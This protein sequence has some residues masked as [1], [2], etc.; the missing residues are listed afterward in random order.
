MAATGYEDDW[1]LASNQTIDP[2][3]SSEHV[4]KNFK[5]RIEHTRLYSKG[6]VQELELLLEKARDGKL[7]E[8]CRLAKIYDKGNDSQP[9]D[10]DKALYW[11]QV[12]TV[13]GLESCR[14]RAR[15]LV[16]S[17]HTANPCFCVSFTEWVDDKE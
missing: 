6:N 17:G 13:F 11:Y 8:I 14:S 10:V 15:E 3:T 12:G 4:K 5:R 2:K 7:G 1:E 16:K 9:R